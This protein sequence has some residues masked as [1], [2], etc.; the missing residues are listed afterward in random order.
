MG[1]G[2]SGEAGGGPRREEK[3][4]AK[5]VMVEG[6]REGGRESGK[7]GGYVWIGERKRE[8]DCR[9]YSSGGCH[10]PLVVHSYLSLP[11]SLP[12]SSLPGPTGAPSLWLFPNVS[13]PSSLP[14]SLPSPPGA[15]SLWPSLGSSTAGWKSSRAS[16]SKSVLPPSLPPSF[17][18]TRF[19]FSQCLNQ[20]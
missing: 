3:N 2:W 19:L 9:I 18:A 7:E 20:E 12:P 1:G 15:P 16:K 10:P 4:K 17:P 5:R 6:G 8:M 14:P 13:T 11:P